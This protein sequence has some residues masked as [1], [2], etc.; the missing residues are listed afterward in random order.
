MR[1]Y[2]AYLKESGFVHE[3]RFGGDTGAAEEIE[4]YETVGVEVAPIDDGGA[5]VYRGDLGEPCHGVAAAL[6]HDTAFD[7]RE[8]QGCVLVFGDE[9]DLRQVT[10]SFATGSSRATEPRRRF[11]CRS[12]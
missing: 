12:Q 11:P 3:Y 10:R 5:G 1:A 2:G 6:D 7:L 9:D 4:D 8:E